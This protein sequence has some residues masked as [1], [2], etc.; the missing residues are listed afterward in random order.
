MEPRC[1]LAGFGPDTLLSEQRRRLHKVS[2]GLLHRA[3]DL[4]KALGQGDSRPFAPVKNRGKIGCVELPRVSLG[5][6]NTS[7]LAE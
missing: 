2:D 1:S 7:D 4:H 3:G 5:Q 6:S